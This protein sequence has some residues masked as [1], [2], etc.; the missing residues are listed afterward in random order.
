MLTT[1]QYRRWTAYGIIS[2]VLER[3]VWVYATGFRCFPNLFVLLVAPPG[4]GKS[5]AVELS[6]KLWLACRGV[7]VGPS[8][9]TK[10][11]LIDHINDECKHEV[12]YNGKSTGYYPLCLASDEFG[13]LLPDHNTDILNIFNSLYDCK[14]LSDRTRKDGLKAVEKPFLTLLA[15]TQPSYLGLILPPTAFEMGFMSRVIMVHAREEE[16]TETTVFGHKEPPELLKDK[17]VHD[18]KTMQKLIGE[19]DTAP[20]AMEWMEDWYKDR[21]IHAPSHPML[22]HYCKRRHASLMKMAMIHSI[23]RNNDLLIELED[24]ESAWATLSAAEEGMPEIFKE[25]TS[26]PDKRVIEEIHRWC[27]RYLIANKTDCVPEAKVMNYIQGKADVHRA[28]Y[29]LSS[30]TDSG[31]LRVKGA[32]SLHTIRSRFQGLPQ[33]MSNDLDRLACRLRAAITLIPPQEVRQSFISH[34]RGASVE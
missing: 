8:G 12:F 27:F 29:F 3:R 23:A 5:I 4:I 22:T 6:E 24:F 21:R 13:I 31:R 18:L 17:L 28:K 32:A 9:L 34:N 19:M 25:M 30:L 14:S 16:Q 7:N 1:D 26:S 20:D 10:A 2:G 33:P 15:G 11:A